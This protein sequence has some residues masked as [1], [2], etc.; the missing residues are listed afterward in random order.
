MEDASPDQLYI[1]MAQPQHPAGSFPHHRK[2]FRQQ[3]IQGFPL[4][5]PQP[6]FLG[7]GAQTG[8]TEPGYFRFQCVDLIHIALA[9]LQFFLIGVPKDQFHQVFQQ[10]YHSSVL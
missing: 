9:D 4:G 5:K 1:E 2:G 7:L 10:V 6:E 3:I 8:I